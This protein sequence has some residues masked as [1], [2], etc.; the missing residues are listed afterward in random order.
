MVWHEWIWFRQK[1]I[2]A[3]LRGVGAILNCLVGLLFVCNEAAERILLSLS[4]VT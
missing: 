4:V 1:E 2:P 3:F